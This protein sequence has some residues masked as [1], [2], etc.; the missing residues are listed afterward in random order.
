MESGATVE[1]E[2]ENGDDAAL[3]INAVRLEMRQRKI[4]FDISSSQPLTLYYGDPALTAPQYDYARLFSPSDAMRTAQLGP[5]QL[6][7]AYRHRPDSRPPTHPHPHLLSPLLPVLLLLLPRVAS[8]P[9]TT[10]P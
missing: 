10:V 3:P 4:C 9:P 6:N 5:E 7:P 2:V 8:P 1:V